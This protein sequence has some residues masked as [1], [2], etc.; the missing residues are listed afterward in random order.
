[1][2][3]RDSWQKLP[4]WESQ[5]HHPFDPRFDD[6]IHEIN[7][8]MVSPCASTIPTNHHS[9]LLAGL[10]KNEGSGEAAKPPADAL[11]SKVSKKCTV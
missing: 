11:H 9:D 3:G 4:Q 10:T 1:L 5:L 6:T 8:W 7:Q 2:N